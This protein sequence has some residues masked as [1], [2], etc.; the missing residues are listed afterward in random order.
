VL[1]QDAPVLIAEVLTRSVELSMSVKSR[2]TR[3]SHHDLS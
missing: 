2:A 3:S 1:E